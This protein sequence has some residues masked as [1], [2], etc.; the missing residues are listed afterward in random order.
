VDFKSVKNIIFDFGAVVINI[1]IPNAYRSFAKLSGMTPEEVRYLFEN[2]GAYADFE[3]GKMSNEDFRALLRKELKLTCSDEEL[4]NAWNSM[5]LD[6]PLERVEKLKELRTR[7]NLFL[8][9]N[10]NAIHVKKMKEMFLQNFGIEDFT[11]LFHKPYLSY[12][13]GLIKPE[14]SIYE[15]VLK[16]AGIDRR[17]TI[18]LDDNADNVKSAL[19]IGLPTIQVLP[20]KYTMMDILKNA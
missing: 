14:A 15:Y 18:F 5:L 3:V 1:D 4:D 8:L 6:I 19:S 17:E 2:Q 13:I 16:D 20:G 9:S 12:E 11:K 10:T 7:Y